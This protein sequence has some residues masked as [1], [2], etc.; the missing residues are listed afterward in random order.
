[1]EREGGGGGGSPPGRGGGGGSPGQGYDRQGNLVG[2]AKSAKEGR[3]MGAAAQKHQ[4][5]MQ[6]EVKKY[7]KLSPFINNRY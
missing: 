1:M 3:L 5:K 6:R 2:A 4:A 7:T